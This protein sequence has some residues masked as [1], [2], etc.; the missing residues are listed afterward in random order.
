MS[1][2]D[3]AKGQ[4]EFQQIDVT[5]NFAKAYCMNLGKSLLFSKWT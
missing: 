1:T 2:C 5:I 4:E 3:L